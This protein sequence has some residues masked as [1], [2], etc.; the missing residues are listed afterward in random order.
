MGF[1]SLFVPNGD[2]AWA[3]LFVT[4]T[5]RIIGVTSPLYVFEQQK[6]P[7]ASLPYQGESICSPNSRSDSSRKTTCGNRG[8]FSLSKS[9]RM[10]N[11]LFQ[12]PGKRLYNLFR[13]YIQLS[14]HSQGNSKDHTWIVSDK[15][16]LTRNAK[17][18][19]VRYP[20]KFVSQHTN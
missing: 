17:V 2:N 15:D 16:L 8:W 4:T 18:L 1:P 6:T 13:R 9:R 12:L 14:C 5:G 19:K 11:I 7:S 10:R 3:T 20:K